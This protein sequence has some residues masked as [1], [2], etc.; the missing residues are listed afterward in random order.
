MKKD[1]P[2]CQETFRET[3]YQLISHT[4]S[5]SSYVWIGFPLSKCKVCWSNKAIQIH[6]HDCSGLFI[7]C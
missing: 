1:I 4:V 6:M 2:K 3:Y 5:F 7:A